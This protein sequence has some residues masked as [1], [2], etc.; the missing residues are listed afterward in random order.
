MSEGRVSKC[1]QRTC[2]KMQWI[3]DLAILNK[4]NSKLLSIP[5]DQLGF[6]GERTAVGVGGEG[7]QV[8]T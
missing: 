6:L 8:L 2:E 1:W 4:A 3:K 7:E 5:C